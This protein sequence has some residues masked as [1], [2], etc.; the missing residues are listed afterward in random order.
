MKL[1]YTLLYVDDVEASLAFY[2]AAFGLPQRFI[3]IVGDQAY[4]ELNTGATTIGFV[5]HALVKANGLTTSINSRDAVPPPFE[6]SLVVDDVDGAYD[7]AIKAGAVPVAEPT[8]KPWGQRL[9]YVRDNQG[10][11][12]GLCSEM[13][14]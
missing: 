2:G 9:A 7:R 6:I 8:D 3:N 14:K 13:A 12:V 5:S 11:L 10:F 1:G 4:G